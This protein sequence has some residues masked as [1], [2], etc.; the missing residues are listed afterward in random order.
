MPVNT[1]VLL[2]V[3]TLPSA[4]YRQYC[5]SVKLEPV[6]VAVKLVQFCPVMETLVSTGVGLVAVKQRSN[7]VPVQPS[8]YLNAIR[9]ISHVIEHAGAVAGK[10]HI[11]III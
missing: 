6:A 9:T 8:R 10:L 3:T 1:P 5:G 2:Q 7:S 4:S 11:A